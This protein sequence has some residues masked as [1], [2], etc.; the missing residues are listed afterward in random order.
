MNTN[1][2]AICSDLNNFAKSLKE[3]VALQIKNIL[4]P[5]AT[6]P[7][8]TTLARQR[9]N[10]H[11]SNPERPWMV[12][13]GVALAVGII[14]ILSSGGTWSYLLSATGVGS[15]LYGQSKKKQHESNTYSQSVSTPIE[16][17]SYEIAK[18]IIEIS[19]SIEAKWRVKVEDCKSSVQRVIKS[20]SASVDDKNSLLSQTYTT[21][22]VSINFDTYVIRI[23]SASVSSNHLILLEYKEYV[24][25]CIAKA[26]T[27]QIAIYNNI[28]Q[29]L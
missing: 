26:A 9:T 12:A 25:S 19:K 1:I 20:S 7:E 27:E 13:G 11:V 4:P 2:D 18:K 22:R 17:K 15:M 8:T 16:P 21:E 3:E 6:N 10:R 29:N 14:G 5:E 28:S 24:D 23:E